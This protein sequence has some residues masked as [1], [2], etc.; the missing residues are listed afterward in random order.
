MSAPSAPTAA[1]RSAPP[2][3]APRRAAAGRGGGTSP[4]AAAQDAEALACRDT[5]AAWECVCPLGRSGDPRADGGPRR[6]LARGAAFATSF[7]SLPA[8]RARLGFAPVAQD[9]WPD[10]PHAQLPDA[11]ACAEPAR[12]WAAVVADL[13][14]VHPLTEVRL[15]LH[16]AAPPPGRT[17]CGKTVDVSP[18]GDFAGEH[19]RVFACGAGAGAG[20]GCPT[21]SAE[22]LAVALDEIPARFVR[23]RPAPAPAAAPR[24]ARA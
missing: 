7:P 15:H 20:A 13:G 10:R 8:A 18:T 24:R 22:G 16:S 3:P 11:G 17:H 21:E 6:D 12:E 23:F 9:A 19:T 14:A 5:D 1:A 4:G 2:R